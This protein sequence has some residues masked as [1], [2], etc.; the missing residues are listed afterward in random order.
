M[1]I[2]TNGYTNNSNLTSL[3]DKLKLSTKKWLLN[4]QGNGISDEYPKCEI[5]HNLFYKFL[6]NTFKNKTEYEND[7]KG[8][9]KNNKN[10]LLCLFCLFV[11]YIII[12]KNK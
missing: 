6:E 1:E 3:K 4:A 11:F 8:G 10:Y 9:S 12:K 5:V 7:F 2:H